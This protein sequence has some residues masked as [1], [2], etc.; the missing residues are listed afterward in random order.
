M[1]QT[2]QE[3]GE[4]INM[5]HVADSA[6]ESIEP[7]RIIEGEV[8]TVDTEFV[9][10]NVGTKSDGRVPLEEFTEQ[11]SVGDSIQ[12]MLKGK[13][14]V[15]GLYQFSKNAAD[16]RKQWDQFIEE[17]DNS[18]G[19]ISGTIL[20][21]TSKGKIVQC[22][23]IHA[24]LPFSLTA[25][26]KNRGASEEIYEFK[27]KSIDKKKK[28]VIL[29]RKDLLDEVMKERW[30][31]FTEKYSIG[32]IITGEVIKFVEFGAFIRIEGLDALL[33]RN[34]MSWKKVFKQRKLLKLG[35]EREFIILDINREDSK[36]SLGL[37]QLNED[38]W[39][40]IDE[41]LSPGDV[42]EGTVVTVT[43][44]GAFV[45]IEDGIEGF[46]SNSDISWTKNTVN[47]KDVLRKGETGKFQILEIN[48]E[49]RKISLGMKQLVEN[50]WD[51]L[52]ERFPVGS[53][54][55]TT[56]KKI[57]KFGIFVEL[58]HEI[59]GLVHNSDITWDENNRDA[60]RQ[61]SVGDEVEVKILEIKKDEMKIACGIRQLTRSPWESIKEKYPPRTMADGVISGI[62]QFG[63]FVKLENDVEGL[64]HISEVSRKRIEDLE[65]FY[66]I[67]EEVS[68]MVLGVDVEKKR[69]SL[70]IKQHDIVSEKKELEK[71]LKDTKPGRV[72]IGDMINF[73]TEE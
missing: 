6:L 73:K 40:S 50:P 7:G 46:V 27:I 63:L 59:D 72:T 60:A 35:E 71:I 67:G 2:L 32:D 8:V 45:E 41:K 66:S 53:V 12:V 30:D 44:Y 11:P 18:E 54:H 70:S 14:L 4:T 49:D 69:L 21:A 55:R 37:K 47:V 29:S 64:V 5:E 57:V 19:V 52:D 38:P 9:Y 68:V 34:D 56:V 23:G 13:R 17:A 26:L 65:E 3:F 33:H 43:T 20:N 22:G 25:D 36:I 58:E 16:D 61:Y 24:F 48:S 10:V 15:D 31:S 1:A 51:T 28:S 42:V 62:T 39:I